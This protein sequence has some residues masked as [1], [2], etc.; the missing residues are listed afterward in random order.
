MSSEDLVKEST[1]RDVVA[2]CEEGFAAQIAS[3][4]KEMAK[5]ATNVESM[6]GML[7]VMESVHEKHVD[8]LAM[9]DAQIDKLKQELSAAKAMR[10]SKMPNTPNKV[11]VEDLAPVISK[12]VEKVTHAISTGLL[13][14]EEEYDMINSSHDNS[15]QQAIRGV[16]EGVIQSTLNNQE[17]TKIDTSAVTQAVQKTIKKA[18]STPLIQSTIIMPEFTSI[19]EAISFIVLDD[20][21]CPT[22]A[23]TCLIEPVTD[24]EEDLPT[25]LEPK[26]EL[27]PKSLEEEQ[28]S[29]PET[30]LEEE[31]LHA[32]D[33]ADDEADDEE[34]EDDIFWTTKNQVC[35]SSDSEVEVE[36]VLSQ[37]NMKQEMPVIDLEYEPYGAAIEQPSLMTFVFNRW[38]LLAVIVYFMWQF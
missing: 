16:F 35:I 36:Q 19:H 38:T 20:H 10:P 7:N 23:S 26:E 24:D 21:H 12:A 18:P 8:A 33:S 27:S 15:L 3:H 22:M 30:D 37:H 1:M 9:R 31:S 17:D 4:Q 28:E 6:Q 5:M 29:L 11:A 2:R 34:E 32:D 13:V 14:E 25:L